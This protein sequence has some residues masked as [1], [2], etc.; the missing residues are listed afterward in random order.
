MTRLYVHAPA[1]EGERVRGVNSKHRPWCAC[2]PTAVATAPRAQMTHMK[3]APSVPVVPAMACL[4]SG[5]WNSAP[6]VPREVVSTQSQLFYSVATAAWDTAAA[7]KWKCQLFVR[8]DALC[9]RPAGDASGYDSQGWPVHR[10]WPS[11]EQHSC[12][13]CARQHDRPHSSWHFVHPQQPESRAG[14]PA[15]RSCEG[16]GAPCCQASSTES[17][18][19]W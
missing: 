16:L 4:P 2:V 8:T 5:R 6:S 3:S 18:T 14:A 12:V 7:C 11:H 15:P 1:P 9:R 10:S 13:A 17:P 19:A